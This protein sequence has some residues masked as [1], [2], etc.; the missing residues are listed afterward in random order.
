MFYHIETEE[1]TAGGKTGTVYT[2]RRNGGP[3]AEIWPAHGFNCL[4]WR[5]TTAEGPH[6]LLYTAPDWH[7]N[8]VPTRSGIPILFPF[9]NRIRDGKF[10]QGWNNYQLPLNDSTRKNAIHG[11]A[12]RHPWRVFGYGADEDAAWI[13]GEF[14]MSVDAPEIRGLWPS[15][16]VL[17]VIYRFTERS[18][19]LESRVKNVGDGPLPFGLGFHPYF[20]F[21]CGDE[22]IDHFKLLAPARSIWTSVDNLPTGER[23]PVADAINWNTPRQIAGTPLDTLYTDLGAIAEHADGLLL[24]AELGH[25]HNPGVLQVWTSRDFRD[26]VLFTP[27]HRQA[28][29]IE[30]YTCATDAVNLAERKIDAG[31]QVL[32]PGEVWTGVVEFRW[33]PGQDL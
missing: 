13:H 20:R 28:V 11:W 8:P 18:L 6:D 1:R 31:W 25:A 30:P 33:D 29:C 15:D 17:S 32:P 21:P 7:T 2:L 22:S 9:P 27:P 10:S 4:R 26:E 24:R 23:Q 16:A 19:R 5:I 12:P 14:Q 3:L